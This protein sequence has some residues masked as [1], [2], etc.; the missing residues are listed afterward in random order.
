MWKCILY[1][2]AIFVKDENRLNLSLL[3]ERTGKEKGINWNN[4]IPQAP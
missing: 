1:T 3:H 4:M 2:V